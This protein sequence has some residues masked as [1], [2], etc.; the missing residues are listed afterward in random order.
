ME[1]GEL[2]RRIL[3]GSHS[4]MHCRSPVMGDGPAL[5]FVAFILARPGALR[6]GS[7]S[8]LCPLHGLAAAM[9][10]VVVGEFLC[11]W[12]GRYPPCDVR[13]LIAPPPPRD[14]ASPRRRVLEMPLYIVPQGYAEACEKHL[15]SEHIARVA[16]S[17]EAADITQAQVMPPANLYARVT[18]GGDRKPAK[19]DLVHLVQCAN[20]VFTGVHFDH[21]QDGLG[22]QLTSGVECVDCSFSRISGAPVDGSRPWRQG[23][24]WV[25]NR[26]DV[27]P[28]PQTTLLGRPLAAAGIGLA[29]AA[30]CVLTAPES[31]S[32]QDFVLQ[33]WV[34]GLVIDHVFFQ[35]ACCAL[36]AWF[37]HAAETHSF[38]PD[39]LP[40]EVPPWEAK[41]LQRELQT[42]WRRA[43]EGVQ[44]EGTHRH[45]AH[46]WR[47]QRGRAFKDTQDK[48]ALTGGG[49][50][51]TEPS[52]Y[53]SYAGDSS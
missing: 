48:E 36:Y 6:K 31:S 43:R 2:N 52:G 17:T 26:H 24:E 39:P 27:P 5:D 10:R 28:P 29:A 37:V 34:T 14:D 38:A 51:V 9:Q 44:S 41:R 7:G 35:T 16:L 22:V 33:L 20:I 15:G 23:P 4:A 21:S 25:M 1:L 49:G 40:C 45:L 19:N 13:H 47:V 11:L 53:S 46:G 3:P 50:G 18:F 42:R 30:L 12:E 32:E 8:R